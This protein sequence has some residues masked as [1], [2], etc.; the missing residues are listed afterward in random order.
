MPPPDPAAPEPRPQPVQARGQVHGSGGRPCPGPPGAARSPPGKPAAAPGQ[1]PRRRQDAASGHRGPAVPLSPCHV[2][3][4]RVISSRFSAPGV[5]VSSCDV[6]EPRHQSLGRASSGGG[7]ERASLLERGK[8]FPTSVEWAEVHRCRSAGA[9]LR[10]P[11]N[12][13]RSED[14]REPCRNLCALWSQNHGPRLKPQPRCCLVRK[15]EHVR[16]I[17]LWQVHVSAALVGVVSISHILISLLKLYSN[18]RH[19][20]CSLRHFFCNITKRLLLQ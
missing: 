13:E 20:H 3:C 2:L 12:Q 11:W 18:S 19:C 14:I 6:E 15:Q 10:G 4:M 1:P 17:Q 8:A 9:V 7:Q 16:A 5:Y